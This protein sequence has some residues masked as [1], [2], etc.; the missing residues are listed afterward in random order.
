MHFHHREQME[1]VQ[2]WVVVLLVKLL[3]LV[4]FYF[5][6]VWNVFVVVLLE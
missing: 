4:L 1:L 5:F 6:V 2:E 3:V